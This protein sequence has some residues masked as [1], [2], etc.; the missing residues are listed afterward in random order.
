MANILPQQ[1]HW[2]VRT[3]GERTTE[4]CVRL[5]AEAARGEPVTRIRETPFV[6]AVRRTCTT[7]VA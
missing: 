6:N 2:I 5:A 3:V 1:I 7:Q 4:A